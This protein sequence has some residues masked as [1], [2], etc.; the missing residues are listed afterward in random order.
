MMRE[1]LPVLGLLL[2]VSLFYAWLN[3][4]FSDVSD[5]IPVMI[6]HAFAAF[7]AIVSTRQWKIPRMVRE[8]VRREPNEN[9]VRNPR[10][11]P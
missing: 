3:P 5:Q 8:P 2:S 7:V 10:N 6:T 4:H 9:L 11:S 1:L